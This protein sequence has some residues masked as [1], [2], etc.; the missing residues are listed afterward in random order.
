MKVPDLSFDYG[1]IHF[2]TAFPNKHLASHNTRLKD[3]LPPQTDSFVF[4]DL[5]SFHNWPFGALVLFFSYA[6]ESCFSVLNS[7]IKR[8]TLQPHPQP[9]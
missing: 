3:R 1:G 5:G 8:E 7:P 4:R 6:S 9:Q 2:E